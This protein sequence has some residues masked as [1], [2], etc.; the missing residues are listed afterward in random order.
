MSFALLYVP[1]R[2]EAANESIR[3]LSHELANVTQ[4]AFNVSCLVLC[5]ADTLSVGPVLQL[6]KQIGAFSCSAVGKTQSSS[7]ELASSRGLHASFLPPEFQISISRFQD[8][9]NLISSIETQRRIDKHQCSLPRR[10]RRISYSSSDQPSA[11]SSTAPASTAARDTQGLGRLAPGRKSNRR[12][13]CS[14]SLD[15]CNRSRAP[16]C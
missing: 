16:C 13:R 15:S 9:N 6:C 7:C 11:A 10:W 5:I 1:Q 2:D 12:R 3:W 14:S 4:R 8:P